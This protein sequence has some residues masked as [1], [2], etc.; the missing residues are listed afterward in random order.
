MNSSFTEEDFI[1]S[2]GSTHIA[3]GIGGDGTTVDNN[4]HDATT[5]SW[6]G[7]SPT[8]TGTHNIES[9]LLVTSPN[10]WHVTPYSYASI[11][12]NAPTDAFRFSFIVQDYYTTAD[13]E[14][15]QNGNLLGVYTNVMS[16]DYLPGGSGEA[17]NTD[18][19]YDFTFTGFSAGDDLEFKLGNFLNFGS[20]SAS[21]SILSSSLNDTAPESIAS[22]LMVMPTTIPEPNTAALVIMAS[23]ACWVRRK[24]RRTDLRGVG[25]RAP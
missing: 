15:R 8:L 18:Y 5:F 14:I 6:T 4:T 21:I 10:H 7:G 3:L 17:H 2:T 22:Q 16:A 19:F 13:L 20:D 11:S 1:S 24:I 9:A 12:V 23:A 25:S